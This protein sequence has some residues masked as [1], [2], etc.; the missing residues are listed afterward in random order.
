M[1]SASAK[2]EACFT[3]TQYPEMHED[4]KTPGTTDLLIRAVSMI[5]WLLWPETEHQQLRPRNSSQRRDRLSLLF[6]SGNVAHAAAIG[7]VIHQDGVEVKAIQ[8]CSQSVVDQHDF[9]ENHNQSGVWGASAEF[10]TMA[11]KQALLEDPIRFCVERGVAAISPSAHGEV[12]EKILAAMYKNNSTPIQECSEFES[13]SR[14]TYCFCI[15]KIRKRL[16][17][18]ILGCSCGYPS[19]SL[20]RKLFGLITR[21]HLQG[22]T[23][24]PHRHP[25]ASKMPDEAWLYETLTTLYPGIDFGVAPEGTGAYQLNLNE[26]RAWYLWDLFVTSLNALDDLSRRLET[27]VQR[28]REEESSGMWDSE[29]D[30]M[31]KG[32]KARA[33]PTLGVSAGLCTA[34]KTALDAIAERMELLYCFA[35]GSESFWQ[36]LTSLTEV[37]TSLRVRLPLIPYQ[38]LGQLDPTTQGD[39]DCSPTLSTPQSGSN[40]SPSNST[41]GGAPADAI[42]GADIVEPTIPAQPNQFGASSFGSKRDFKE[43][44]AHI[45]PNPPWGDGYSDSDEISD[46]GGDSDRLS[47]VARG[48]NLAESVQNKQIAIKVGITPRPVEP[49]KQASLRSAL[50]VVVGKDRV[51]DSM[52]LILSRARQKW[53]DPNCPPSWPAGKT[54]VTAS[55]SNTASL[56]SWEDQFIPSSIHCEACLVCKMSGNLIRNAVIGASRRCCLCCSILLKALG[57]KQKNLSSPGKVYPY[58]PPPQASE[59]VKDKILGVLKERLESALESYAASQESG[60]PSPPARSWAYGSQACSPQ[61]QQ[62]GGNCI[63]VKREFWNLIQP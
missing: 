6:V 18:P 42:F 48:G 29:H 5:L 55:L 3:T 1:S 32:A 21:K 24:A 49:T 17:V 9:L 20:D 57:V 15:G 12:I 53:P 63:I 16:A 52:A 33:D 43:T 10:D 30:E 25:S 45:D 35:H 51:D 14:Y 62:Y 50:E 4:D 7:V 23:F 46:Y 2:H 47:D 28:T 19:L 11:L 60:D 40:S 36:V 31:P 34:V 61:I 38:S 58:A 27:I 54:L 26:E 39:P 56:G 8:E 22:L 59:Q 13:L 44:K 37:L 41:Q